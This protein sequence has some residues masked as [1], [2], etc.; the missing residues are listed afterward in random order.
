MDDRKMNQVNMTTRSSILLGSVI[1]S[2]MLEYAA[3]TEFLM[4]FGIVF[5]MILFWSVTFRFFL[6]PD[7]ASL[8]IFINTVI[9][10]VLSVLAGDKVSDLILV[11]MS[12]VGAGLIAL[13]AL[14]PDGFNFR[15]AHFAKE[16]MMPAAAGFISTFLSCAIMRFTGISNSGVGILFAALVLVVVSFLSARIFGLE[17]LFT[18]KRLTDVSDIK[19]NGQTDLLFFVRGKLILFVLSLAVLAMSVILEKLLPITGR[20][21]IASLTVISSAVYMIFAFAGKAGMDKNVFR[22][23]L[24]AYECI[25]FAAFV[26]YP[27]IRTAPLGVTLDLIPRFPMLAARDML[28]VILL[29]ICDFTIIGLIGSYN[30]KLIFG[31]RG[32]CVDGMPLYLVVASILIM[33]GNCFFMLY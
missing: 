10:A 13:S 11:H 9:A 26:N 12:P 28:L 17:L 16:I 3:G 6:N 22:N 31:N 27:I 32:R 8:G 21:E 5:A 15:R 33:V 18:S 23:K 14:P 2:V 19:F 30:R 4:A 25:M 29:M 24:L 1:V 20:I 7:T